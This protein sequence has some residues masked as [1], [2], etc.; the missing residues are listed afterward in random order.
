M[1]VKPFVRPYIEPTD[2]KRAGQPAP[3]PTIQVTIG[4]IEVRATSPATPPSKP[5]AASP[6]MSLDEYL[7]RRKGGGA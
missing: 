3:T 5:R 2:F 4:R 6:A 1:V 7:R